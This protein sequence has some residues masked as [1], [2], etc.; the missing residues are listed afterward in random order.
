MDSKI[1]H[2]KQGIGWIFGFPTANYFMSHLEQGRCLQCFDAVGWATGRHLVCKRRV[3]G[4]WHGYLSVC[5]RK[6][7]LALAQLM[8]LPQCHSLSV[9]LENPDWFY[10][11]SAVFWCKTIKQWWK[12]MSITVCCYVLKWT[13]TW[14]H[15][16][17]LGLCY[18]TLALPCECVICVQLRSLNHCSILF[19]CFNCL[20]L[21]LPDILT[22]RFTA[23]NLIARYM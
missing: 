17:S 19:I 5:F 3:V 6:S 8:P 7:R 18:N 9:A 15:E 13:S 22:L 23:Q 16:K 12:L 20:L 14:L 21:S 2:S 1:E 11:L 10:C 4:C